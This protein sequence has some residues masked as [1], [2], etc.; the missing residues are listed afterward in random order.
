MSSFPEDTARAARKGAKDNPALPDEVT[1]T[2]GVM[3]IPCEDCGQLISV[4]AEF[5][6]HCGA[7]GNVP[8]LVLPGLN[9]TATSLSFAA[10]AQKLGFRRPKRPALKTTPPV[11][12]PQDP[13]PR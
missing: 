3:L 4:R 8:R 7:R 1:Q 6:S 10:L 5:C 12:L 9:K 11:P 13:A 2:L